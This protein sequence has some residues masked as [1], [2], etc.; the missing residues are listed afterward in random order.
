VAVDAKMTEFMDNDVVYTLRWG[1]NELRIQDDATCPRAAA[2]AFLHFLQAYGWRRNTES[3]DTRV[4]LLDVSI[5]QVR[6]A[7]PVPILDERANA[8]GV[9]RVRRIHM[10][11]TANQFH[12]VLVS[13]VKL[14]SVLSAQEEMCF[15]ANISSDW[16]SR[17]GL[18]KV[19]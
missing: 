8:M 15:T 19:L 14:Q 16:R 17:R 11:I 13:R 6:R 12:R 3:L 18:A 4:A 1:L 2:P 5:K 10:E 7:L 9:A